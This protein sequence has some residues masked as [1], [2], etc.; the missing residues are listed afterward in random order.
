MAVYSII[1]KSQLE[2]ALRLDAEYYQPEYLDIQKKLRSIKVATILDMAE[3]VISF[4]AYSLCNFIEWQEK[5]VPYLNVQNIQDG[6]IDFDGVKF[7]SEKVDTVL[8]KSKVEE[9]QVLLT[10]AGTIGNAAVAHKIPEKVNS[11]QAIAKITLKK[12]FSPYYL[13]A[14]LNSYYGS[15]QTEREIVSS[16]QPNIFLGQI[17]EFKVPL[18]GQ[19]EQQEIGNIYR[20]GL[21]ALEN[22][23][24]FY[25]QAENLLLEE[26]GLN[27]FEQEVANE[28]NFTIFNLSEAQKA[29]RLDAEY[30][31]AVYKR[32]VEKVS[33]KLKTLSLSDIFEFTR[34]VFVPTEFYTNKK[35][36]R[37]FIRIKEL[38]G[39]VGINEQGVVFINEKYPKDAKNTLFENDLVIA[40]IGDTIG[41][42]NLIRKELSGGFCSN[43]MARLRI[44]REWVGKFLPEFS[45]IL[46]QSFFI[47]SQIKQKMAQTGQPKIS[48][49]ELKSV[50]IPVLPKSTQQKIADLIRQSHEARRRATSLLGD[51]KAKVENLIES[52]TP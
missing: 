10:M 23:K 52:K 35:T 31:Q 40:I 24:K 27:D 50:I 48:D 34:G 33:Q 45:E 42:V 29:N 38:S 18:V 16:V 4:G 46:F 3:S 41:K 49:K 51:A 17:K 44:K 6:F 9:G 11:N 28:P 36:V 30:F 19:K 22:S 37:P 39:K 21:G 43:N 32:V 25:S 8:K 13:V 1:Q 7:I 14:F 20:E 15:K 12:S 5:G 26:L 2:G 47:Q